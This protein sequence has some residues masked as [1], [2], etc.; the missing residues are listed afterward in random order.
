MLI[1]CACSDMK[2]QNVLVGT[3]GVVKL[4]DFGFAREMSAGTIMLTSIKGEE[5]CR[6]LPPCL[7]HA[8][9]LILVVDNRPRSL[10]STS[11]CCAGTPLY[12][13]PEI[14]N[15]QRYEFTADLWG[16]AV[17]LYVQRFCTELAS[18]ASIPTRFACEMPLSVSQQVSRALHSPLS[19]FAYGVASPQFRARLRPAAVLCQLA[20][21][22]H[23]VDCGPADRVPCDHVG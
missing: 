16:L 18:S 3:G 23:A 2:P 14:F 6:S 8:T 17:M 4:C 22:A 1:P 21:R 11:D 15:D 7:L 13:A 20:A 9:F 5:T 10:S 19:S 12:M